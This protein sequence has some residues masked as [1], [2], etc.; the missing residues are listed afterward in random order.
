MWGF[1]LGLFTFWLFERSPFARA[2]LQGIHDGLHWVA[3]R[4]DG[5]ERKPAQQPQEEA[6]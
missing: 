5:N 2:V 6:D 3:D 4:F 1:L